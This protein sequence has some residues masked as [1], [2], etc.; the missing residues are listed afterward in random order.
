MLAQGNAPRGADEASSTRVCCVE[1]EEEEE[2]DGE[3]ASFLKPAYRSAMQVIG[4]G[5]AAR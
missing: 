3:R 2:G 5:G 1:E 4:S